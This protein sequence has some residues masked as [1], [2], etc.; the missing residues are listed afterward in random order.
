MHPDYDMEQT[1]TDA[2]PKPTTPVSRPEGGTPMPADEPTATPSGGT[3]MP[4][5]P[6]KP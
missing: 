2:K 5:N 6:P 1:M 3:P 4:A